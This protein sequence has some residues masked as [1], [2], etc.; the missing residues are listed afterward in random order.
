[1]RA[2]PT[3][4]DDTTVDVAR[5]I[6]GLTAAASRSSDA[7]ACVPTFAPLRPA[8]SIRPQSV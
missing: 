2:W 5:G 4:V 8:V 3:R 6:T 1:M 7:L